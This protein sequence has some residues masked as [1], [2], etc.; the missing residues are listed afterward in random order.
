VL[1]G[2][3]GVGGASVLSER[4]PDLVEGD[5]AYGGVD[6]GDVDPGEFGPVQVHAEPVRV[7]PGGVDQVVMG[8]LL[9]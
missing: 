2:G 5:A 6:R 7:G 3:R 1:V 9:S 8:C 4:V